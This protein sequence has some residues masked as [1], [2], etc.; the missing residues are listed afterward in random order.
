[1]A[2]RSAPVWL[3][4]LEVVALQHACLGS[5]S[6]SLKVLFFAISEPNQRLSYSIVLGYVDSQIFARYDSNSREIQPQVSWMEKLRK[7]IPQYWQALTNLV[8]AENDMFRNDLEDWRSDYNKDKGLHMLQGILSCDL[9][10]DGSKR[11][12]VQ[13]A[14]NGVTI[15]KS[16]MDACNMEYCICIELLEKFLS[17]GNE[18]LLRTETPT[19]TVSSRTE[20]EDGMEMHVCRVHGFYPREI[21]ASWTRDGEVWLQ[22]TLHGSIAPNT[23]GTYHYWLSIQIDPKERGRYRCHV[24]HD[25]LQEPLDLALK[26]PGSNLGLI[27]GCFAIS[28]VMVC[29]IVGTLI[30]L[31]NHRQ[32]RGEPQRATSF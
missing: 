27:I 13:G 21:D 5:S 14:Y 25:G 4:V 18:T 29:G 20:V 19:V 2:L 22:D 31:R 16:N 26:V 28:L 23:D 11:Q 15:N 6:H 17:Y 3:L 10:G 1:M 24:E 12:F 32:G 9:Q 30:F 8:H 7:D